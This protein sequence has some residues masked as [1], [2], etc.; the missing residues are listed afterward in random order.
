MQFLCSAFTWKLDVPIVTLIKN[1]TIFDTAFVLHAKCSRCDVIYCMDHIS[2]P[3]SQSPSRVFLNSAR[4]MK[5][6]QSLWVDR[7]FS[8]AVLSGIYS[9]HA[10]ANAYAQFWNTSYL[11]QQENQLQSITY[12]HI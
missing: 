2:I 5:I 9:F 6:G 8:N 11:E 4:Y 3:Q 10:S 7:V 12:R 1:T